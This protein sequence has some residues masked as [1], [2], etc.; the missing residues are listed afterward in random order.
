[1]TKREKEFKELV[2][3]SYRHLEKISIPVK[4]MTEEEIGDLQDYYSIYENQP[5]LEEELEQCFREE[6]ME[7]NTYTVKTVTLQTGG[8]SEWIDFKYNQFNE[9]MSATHVYM[10]GNQ[11]SHRS[12]PTM[13]AKR[14][15][16]LWGI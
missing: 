5:P 13:I 8:P 10:Y 2:N 6:I 9:L 4:N 14:L 1:M 16:N 12:I 15:A 3:S 11:H 7:V